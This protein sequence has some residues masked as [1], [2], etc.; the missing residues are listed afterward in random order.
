MTRGKV[1][2]RIGKLLALAAEDS[3]GTEAERANALAR[4]QELMHKHR[5][6]EHEL[7]ASGKERLPGIEPDRWLPKLGMSKWWLIDLA[8]HVGEGVGVDCIYVPRLA[9]RS[10]YLVGRPESIEYVKLVVGWIQPQLERDARVALKHYKAKR[11]EV[12]DWPENVGDSAAVSM[13]YNR[14]FY[15][16]AVVAIGVRLEAERRKQERTSSGTA[17]VVSDKAA[18]AE[19]YGDNAPKQV[20]QDVYSGAGA[21][22]GAVSGRDV[23]INPTNKLEEGAAS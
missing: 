5:V 17:L 18:L 3:G 8:T 20:Q 9:S 11:K 13:S 15:G 14:S 19:F 12:G 23:D 16:H 7:A 22:A 21:A 1:V 4:A 2:D 6:E 10:V